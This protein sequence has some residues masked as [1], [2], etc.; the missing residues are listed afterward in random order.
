[1]STGVSKRSKVDLRLPT[2][3]VVATVAAFWPILDN[4]FVNW[5]DP[6]VLLQN[7]HLA[8]PG[9]LRWAFTTDLIGHYQP[10]SWLMWSALKSA[11]GLSAAAFHGLSLTAHAVNGLLVFVLALHL[12]RAAKLSEGRC[13]I[14]ATVAC[15]TF[16]LHPLRVEPVAWASAM[17]YLASL[18]MTLLAAI[19]YLNRRTGLSLAC[20]AMGLLTRASAIG[21]PFALLLID[22]YPLDRRRGA[23]MGR[24]LREKIP[25]A[26][27]AV[28]AAIAE[29][30]TRES[31][32]L[33]EVG[34]G[35]RLT[36]AATAPFEYLRGMI[37]PVRLTPLNALPIS[38]ATDWTALA[39]GTAA[40]VLL[41]VAVWILRRAWPPAIVGWL[42]FLA[43][44]APVAGLTPTGVQATADRYTYVPG[45]VVSILFGA[46]IAR[47]NSSDRPQLT[48]ALPMAA[49]LAV[50]GALTWQQTHYWHDSIA[51]WTRATDLDP[52]NDVAAYNLA[53]AYADTGREA[54]A[55]EW[56]ERTLRIVPDHELARQNLALLQA[57]QAE[58]DGNQLARAGRADDAVAQYTRALALDNKRVHA[59]AARG[60][61]LAQRGELSSAITDLRLALDGGEADP[62]VANVLAFAL[63]ETGNDQEAS[64]VLTKALAAH[65]DN[66]NLRRNLDRL[67]TRMRA[68]RR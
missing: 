49:V 57:A 17:P 3:V 67:T 25:F 28:A 34:I 61:L 64:A 30:L 56:Y 10:L 20:Y 29:A 48:L 40:L 2:L 65:P 23:T 44:L 24:L 45:V 5:D 15:F 35:P 41:T 16:A 46:L 55:I 1:V 63:A 12:A 8:S 21:L 54:D 22:L 52:R 9:I 4:G 38:P 59:R 18:S 62:E 66:A 47:L 68:P 50:L 60:I 36:M 39:M 7:A 14:L 13:R 33:Q 37:L 42:A 31:T 11:F 6:D 26:L 32:T 53:I 51:L 19:A 58:R 43:L 27:L